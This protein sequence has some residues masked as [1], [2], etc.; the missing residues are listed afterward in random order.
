MGVQ[1]PR[2]ARKKKDA[3]QPTDDRVIVVV[4]KDTE[5]YRDWVDGLSESTLIPVASIVRDAL[6]K[7]AQER[8]LPSPPASAV[9]RRR[10]KS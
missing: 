7:W 1:A 2:M 5:E 6:A 3:P 4:L 9:R 10:R 8:G